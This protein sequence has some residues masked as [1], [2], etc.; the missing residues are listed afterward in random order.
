MLPCAVI[1]ANGV[2]PGGLTYNTS[3]QQMIL[4]QA[5]GG[6]A[7][8]INLSTGAATSLGGGSGINDDDIAYDA[9]NNKYWAMDWSGNLFAYDT[10][11]NQTS[12]G[13]GFGSVASVEVVPTPEPAS[14][15]VL[16][17]GIVAFARRRRK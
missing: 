13:T 16:G 11:F 10:A 9:A 14:L 3:T 15:A 7:Y 17:L 8:S 5:G 4:L 1:G 6:N 2:Y 12:V